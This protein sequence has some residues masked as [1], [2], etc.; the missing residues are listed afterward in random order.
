MSGA[1]GRYPG[2]RLVPFF[3]DPARGS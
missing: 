1:L 3:D 2:T